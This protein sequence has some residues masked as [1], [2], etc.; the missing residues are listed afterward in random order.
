MAPRRGRKGGGAADRGRGKRKPPKAGMAV[1][2]APEGFTEAH[3]KQLGI[4]VFGCL[5]RLGAPAA[6]IIL[7][8]EKDLSPSAPADT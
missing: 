4:A 8:P 6:T 3:A 7:D 5:R 1:L 2:D